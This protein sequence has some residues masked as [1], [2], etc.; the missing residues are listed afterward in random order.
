MSLS[1]DHKAEKAA[2]VSVTGKTDQETAADIVSAIEE[3]RLLDI[4]FWI[5]PSSA[6]RGEILEATLGWIRRSEAELKAKA[7]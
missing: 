1:R 7:N 6:T 4:K 5:D 3:G 2:P